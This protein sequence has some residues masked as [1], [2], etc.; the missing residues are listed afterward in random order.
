MRKDP[1]I[2]ALQTEYPGQYGCVRYCDSRRNQVM[3]VPSFSSGEI[4]SNEWC[5]ECSQSLSEHLNIS[6]RQN[7]ETRA[8]TVRTVQEAKIGL[9]VLEIANEAVRLCILER[10]AEACH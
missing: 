9:R 5:Y 1:T 3:E 4:R 2:L 6:T 10:N 8:H 7:K